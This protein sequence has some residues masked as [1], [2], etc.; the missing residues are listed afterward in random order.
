MNVMSVS[1]KILIILLFFVLFVSSVKASDMSSTHFI[2]RDPVIG[3]M[4]D[5]GTSTN[6]SLIDSGDTIFTNNASSTNFEINFGFLYYPQVTLGTL[7]ATPVGMQ[8]NLSWGA[9]TGVSG[10]NVSG[11]NTGWST[12]SGGPYTYTSVGNVT[13][14]SYT[15]LAPGTYYYV[16]QTL[17]G[18]GNVI[19]TSNEASATIL[20]VI[21]YSINASTNNTGTATTIPLGTLTTATALG[22]NESTIPSI[23]SNLSTNAGSGVVVSVVSANGALKSTSTPADAIPSSTGTMTA[24][25]ANYGICIVSVAQ[26]SGAT[27]TRGTNF[28]STTCSHTTPAGNTVSAVTTSPQSLLTASSLINSGIAEIAVDAENNA[29]TPA[30]TDYADTLTLIGTGTF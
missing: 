14:Y 24:G 4:G 7:S 29:S 28:P 13:S 16:V 25:T 20:P 18:L 8:A 3:T 30:H 1:K 12:T 26:T 11:Y 5:S 21:S 23:W 27:L 15:S 19:G 2:I 17:D 22:S 6:F 9:S 10:W